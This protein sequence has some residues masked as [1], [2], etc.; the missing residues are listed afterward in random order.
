M[1]SVGDGLR[2]PENTLE[3]PHLPVRGAVLCMGEP[4][5]PG[6]KRMCWTRTHARR[7]TQ[8]T[9]KDLQTHQKHQQRVI[10]LPDVQNCAW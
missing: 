8:E 9:R 5:G 4:E 1:H 7:V 2:T 6:T 10:Y 3:S